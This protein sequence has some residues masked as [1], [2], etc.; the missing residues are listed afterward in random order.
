MASFKLKLFFEAMKRWSYDSSFFIFIQNKK[1]KD[2]F[3]QSYAVPKKLI[4]F[5]R[6]RIFV[7]EIIEK[8]LR[9]LKKKKNLYEKSS[10]LKKISSLPAFYAKTFVTLSPQEDFSH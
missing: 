9:D 7:K 3:F 2:F 5:S 6:K 8:S 1:L 4:A 10:H